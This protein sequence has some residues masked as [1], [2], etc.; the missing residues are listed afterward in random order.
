MYFKK[1]ISSIVPQFI[2]VKG[3]RGVCII[4]RN[5]EYIKLSVFQSAV[6]SKGAVCLR[7][8]RF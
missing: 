8:S 7:T 4:N 3:G 1:P 5:H 6:L 2:P